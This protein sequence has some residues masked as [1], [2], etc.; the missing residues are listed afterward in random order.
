MLDYLSTNQPRE[1]VDPGFHADDV[2][3]L[4]EGLSSNPLVQEMAFTALSGVNEA[5]SQALFAELVTLGFIARA[6]P[7]DAFGRLTIAFTPDALNFTLG[8]NPPYD[9]PAE[10]LR[11]INLLR[12]YHNP[13]MPEAARRQRILDGL[14]SFFGVAPER[15]AALIDF[16]DEPLTPARIAILT[17]TVNGSDAKYPNIVRFLR[18]LHARIL[19]ANRLEL[20]VDE[21]AGVVTSAA[22]FGLGALDVLPFV[23][24]RNLDRYRALTDK[25]GDRDGRLL[26]C[27]SQQPADPA[28]LA[29][30]T[31]W[32]QPQI[33]TV[34]AALANNL[35]LNNV[36]G[37]YRTIDGLDRL[38]R[39]FDLI[40]LL[41]IDARTL[42]DWSDWNN[43][44]LAQQEAVA[45]ATLEV[46][47]A[48]YGE[49]AWAER[50]EPVEDQVREMKRDALAAWLTWHYRPNGIRDREGSTSSCS[51]TLT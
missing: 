20:R 15:V 5:Q 18:K 23:A 9:T 12:Q 40:R 44:T 22:A 32:D 19:V 17:T 21:I 33:E 50:F 10:E 24:V 37:V 41:K 4:P 36:D 1:F 45:Q 3:T 39:C 28:L 6:Q 2:R 26:Q 42:L 35:G 11:V 8:L 43:K 48:R 49:D 30:L 51:S 31:G 7:D 25:F 34:A 16:T 47:K 29:A 27:I 14:A 46:F 38:A 13:T